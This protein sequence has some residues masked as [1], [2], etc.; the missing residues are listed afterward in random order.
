VCVSLSR[1]GVCRGA[2]STP[3]AVRG[4]EPRCR[5]RAFAGRAGWTRVA[6]SFPRHASDSGRTTARSVRS[7]MPEALTSRP[8]RTSLPCVVKSHSD[9]L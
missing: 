6:A 8:G 2:A 9:V 7:A 3:I 4:P 1:L 5:G